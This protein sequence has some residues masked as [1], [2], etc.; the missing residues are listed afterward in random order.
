MGPHP[1]QPLLPLSAME[2]HRGETPSPPA[3]RMLTAPRAHR[4]LELAPSPKGLW[5]WQAPAWRLPGCR[6]WTAS[7]SASAGTGGGGLGP[8]CGPVSPTPSSSGSSKDPEKQFLN[9]QDPVG[10]GLCSGEPA[11]G[12]EGEGG[13]FMRG[14]AQPPTAGPSFHQMGRQHS[15][16]LPPPGPPGPGAAASAWS[17]RQ[18]T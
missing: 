11:C 7:G 16:S 13:V 8:N 5:P 10:Q 6:G 1:V 17:P 3:L 4:G 12:W 14:A 2:A 18:A 9:I 15:L